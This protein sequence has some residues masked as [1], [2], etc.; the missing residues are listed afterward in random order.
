MSAL[1]APGLG[2]GLELGKV[3]VAVLLEVAADS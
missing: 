2:L 3:E 1:L